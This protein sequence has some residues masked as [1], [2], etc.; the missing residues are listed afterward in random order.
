MD[1]GQ[2]IMTQTKIEILRAGCG[3]CFFIT[4]EN[5]D[6]K[7]RI[8]VDGGV[9][10]TYVDLKC[11]YP[12]PGDLKSK[13]IS[14]K[15]KHEHI[16]LL[17][18]THI[19]DDHIG[20]LLEWFSHDFPDKTLLHEVWFNDNVLVPSYRSTNNSKANAISLKCLLDEHGVTYKNGI[21]QGQTYSI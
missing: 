9:A 6:E 12:M 5:D 14:L 21:I 16:D 8:L 13:L 4:I 15:S 7:F 11:G 20:G 18:I 19:D 10:A 17:I 2:N 1:K 3:D